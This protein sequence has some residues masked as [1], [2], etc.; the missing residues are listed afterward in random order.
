MMVESPLHP[1]LLVAFRRFGVLVSLLLERLGRQQN[2]NRR[3]FKNKFPEKTK[4][5]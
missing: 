4:Q 2:T 1:L 3:D 5:N